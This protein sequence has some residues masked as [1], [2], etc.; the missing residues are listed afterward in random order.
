[1]KN[2]LLYFDIIYKYFKLILLALAHYFIFFKLSKITTVNL[3][4]LDKYFLLDNT[5]KITHD[6]ST[7]TPNLTA[8]FLVPVQ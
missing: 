5:E 7:D 4:S 1:M 8:T 6:F 3:D 2:I